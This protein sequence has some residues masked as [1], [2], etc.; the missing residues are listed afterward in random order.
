MS[1][2]RFL[3]STVFLKHL[4]L[5]GAASL[6]LVLL[7][8][9]MLKFYTRHGESFEVPDLYGFNIQE[10]SPLIARSHLRYQIVDSTYIEELRPGVI[11]EQLPK[12]GH[13]VKRNRI[14]QLTINRWNPEQVAVPRLT[15]ISLRQ[16]LAQLEAAGLQPGE[17]TMRPSEFQNLV[18]HA[19][20][21]GREL[22]VGELVPRG[23]RID[24]IVGTT[25]MQ[26]QVYLPDFKGLTLDL[27]RQIMEELMLSSGAVIYDSSVVT[28]TDSIYARVWRQQPDPSM[29]PFINRGAAV[30]L[31]VTTNEALFETPSESE[32]SEEPESFF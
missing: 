11:V 3:T 29:S 27:T 2:K 25:G 32:A 15:D 5:A 20:L 24:L 13:R 31:W 22:L 12:A 8:L 18:L 10:S 4:V 7:V 21:Q 16:S 9:F 17:I 1:I 6:L 23:T 26:E 19:T 28:A 14:I 30:D